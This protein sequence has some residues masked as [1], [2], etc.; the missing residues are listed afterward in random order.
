VRRGSIVQLVVIGLLSG[1]IATCV[2]ILVPWLPTSATTQAERID[3]TYWFATVISLVVF[4]V[5]AAVLIY[6]II[7]FRAKPGD[8]SDGPPVHGHTMLEIVWTV[9]P[10]V[11]VTSIA[12][13]SAVVLTQ[14]GNAGTS[15]LKIDVIAQQFS[16]QFKYGNGQTFPVLRLPVDRK[17]ELNITSNDVIH[18]FW[19]PQFGQKQDAVPGAPQSLVITPN[20]LGTYPVICTE[21]CGLGHSLMRSQAIVM[22]QAE[23]DDWY[24][25]G[26]S[27][28]GG[29]GGG[30]SGSGAVATFTDNG[31]VACHT[32][33]AIPAAQGKIGP[34]LDNLS[35][36]AAK[37]GLPL[38]EFIRQS[39][40][41]P[42]AYVAPGYVAG[43][44]PSFKTQISAEKLD[45]L[46]QYLAENT[47]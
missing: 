21:L 27:P 34:S 47:K 8:W 46:V 5:V 19:V 41:D 23:Y 15:P 31:C 39:I 6:S 24:E 37:A 13:V 40:V 45:E 2:A 9:I 22:T 17:I 14:N 1:T 18:S 36:A 26:G 29:G 33:S 42:G 4:A 30:P 25:K 10:T 7:N 38:D 11:L 44:M 32:F 16:W 12:I 43:T 28:G 20:R 3:F 35:E